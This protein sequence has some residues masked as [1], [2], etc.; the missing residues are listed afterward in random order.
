MLDKKLFNYYNSIKVVVSGKDWLAVDDKRMRKL[1][2]MAS[3]D[4]KIGRKARDKKEFV[5]DSEY[6]IYLMELIQS[7]WNEETGVY[8]SQVVNE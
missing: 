7:A 5:N 6:K 4:V 2:D 1:S 8:P 3:S